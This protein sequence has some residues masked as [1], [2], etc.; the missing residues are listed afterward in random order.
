MAS[1]PLYRTIDHTDDIGIEVEAPSIEGI[2]TRSGLAVFD[3]MFGLDSI[4]KML[5][6]PIRVTAESTEELLVAWLNELLYVCAVERTVF[7]DFTDVSLD[8]NMLSA[9]G[10]G[11]AF[12]P[13]RHRVSMEIKAAT[14]HGMSI[15]EEE[16]GWKARMIFDV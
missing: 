14:Y 15:D 5:T 8:E 10:V 11:E 3:L 16:G 1:E 2:F 9:V 12:D 7:S 6:R 4:G 13:D